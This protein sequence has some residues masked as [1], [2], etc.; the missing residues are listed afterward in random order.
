MHLSNDPTARDLWDEIYRAA[1]MGD[2]RELWFV[3]KKNFPTRFWRN[4]GVP[5]IGSLCRDAGI[6]FADVLKR[7]TAYDMS[8][9]RETREVEEQRVRDSQGKIRIP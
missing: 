7:V 1:V 2:D 3:W 5:G 9:D 8:L 6:D 4:L